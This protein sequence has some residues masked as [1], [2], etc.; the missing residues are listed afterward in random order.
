MEHKYV[1]TACQHD[2]HDECRQSCKFCEASCLCDCHG[3]TG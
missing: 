3:E 2:R 1:S